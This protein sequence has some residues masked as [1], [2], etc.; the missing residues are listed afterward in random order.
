MKKYAFPLLGLCILAFFGCGSAQSSGDADPSAS[1]NEPGECSL[2]SR[3]L[4]VDLED[5]IATLQRPAVAVAKESNKDANSDK[6]GLVAVFLEKV[7]A[8]GKIEPGIYITTQSTHG[9]SLSDLVPEVTEV[10]ETLSGVYLVFAAPFYYKSDARCALFRIKDRKILECIDQESEAIRNVS[11]DGL[12]NI[13]YESFT[14][15]GSFVRKTKISTQTFTDLFPIQW[16]TY[17]YNP[18]PKW[19]VNSKG[20]VLYQEERQ[21]MRF[22]IDGKN[23]FTSTDTCSGSQNYNWVTEGQITDD[24]SFLYPCKE[25]DD[26]QQRELFKIKKRSFAEGSD[27]TV[28]MSSQETL[29]LGSD[30]KGNIWVIQWNGGN[31]MTK[32]DPLPAYEFQSNYH[33]HL[34]NV[35]PGETLISYKTEDDINT[36]QF[37]RYSLQE[38]QLREEPAF[39][40]GKYSPFKVCR[41]TQGKYIFF[42]NNDVD[43][44][45]FM[46][47]R[48]EQNSL[49]T[50]SLQ[51]LPM[52]GDQLYCAY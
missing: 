49:V 27:I 2:G 26:A 6:A 38:G 43:P 8:N 11:G 36:Y 51:F 14:S 37:N 33:S 9:L 41:D 48:D 17:N 7:T 3:C 31:R 4:V 32:I 19:K 42:F 20:E 46:A 16:L 5:A 30:T 21:I 44:T 22:G 23:S 39:N 29:Y 40:A 45:A 52:Q 18:E 1:L 10:K 24:G 15:K 13:Y 34:S 25:W 35:M 12:G 28:I 47:Y 50:N